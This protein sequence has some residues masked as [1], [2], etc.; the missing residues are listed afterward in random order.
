L[1]LLQFFEPKVHFFSLFIYL[2]FTVFG[3][4]KKLFAL[5]SHFFRCSIS[6]VNDQWLWK[7]F[8]FSYL[9]LREP[10]LIPF[11]PF[12]CRKKRKKT[13]KLRIFVDE[14]W[15]VFRA[16]KIIP[17][18]MYNKCITRYEFW[19]VEVQP[20][21]MYCLYESTV[22]FMCKIINSNGF[23]YIENKLVSLL[24][25]CLNILIKSRDVMIRDMIYKDWSPRAEKC[26][27][28]YANTDSDVEGFAKG[29][30]LDLCTNFIYVY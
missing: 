12:D 22:L 8:F 15:G 10:L 30:R 4:D 3:R 29:K 5:L 6:V 26:Q 21:K 14:T 16:K 18:S 24:C 25:F 13:F 23:H 2:L 9:F 17:Y 11:F 7:W 1:F 28:C 20:N 19:L 27:A